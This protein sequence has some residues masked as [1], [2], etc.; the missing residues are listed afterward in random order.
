[1]GQPSRYPT[2]DQEAAQIFK[3]NSDLGR[4]VQVGGAMYPYDS[5]EARSMRGDYSWY[6]PYVDQNNPG[7]DTEKRYFYNPAQYNWGSAIPDTTGTGGNYSGGG[8]GG[9]GGYGR[10][11]GGGYGGGGSGYGGG[12][13]SVANF[14]NALTN[15]KILQVQGG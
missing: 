2:A 1:M 4:Y 5:P 14:Y 10:G 9:Y 12:S 15:W 11:G 13:S 7:T 8:G 6:Q 3:R